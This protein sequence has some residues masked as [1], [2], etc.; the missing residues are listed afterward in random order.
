MVFS[1]ERLCPNCGEELYYYDTVKRIVKTKNGIKNRLY[2]KR[3]VCHNC[4]TYHR[5]LPRTILPYK[6][7][8]SE[9]IYGV[10]DGLI[11]SETLGYEDYPCEQTMLRWRSQNLQVV[12]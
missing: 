11:T 7:Y 5:E 2:I 12:L 9:I 6:Q 3:M 10:I 4:K 1:N 8:E